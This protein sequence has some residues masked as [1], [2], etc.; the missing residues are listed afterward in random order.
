MSTEAD[1]EN[2]EK[3][4]SILIRSI[5]NNGCSEREL[6][7][8]EQYAAAITALKN[9]IAQERRDAVNLSAHR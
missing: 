1:L 5:R 9:K 2:V 3:A 8:L 4:Q 6:K 7:R